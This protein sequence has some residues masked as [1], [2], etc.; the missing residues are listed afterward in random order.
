MILPQTNT[1][2]QKY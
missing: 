1:D 2:L